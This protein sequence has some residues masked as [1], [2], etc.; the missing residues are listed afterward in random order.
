[1]GV[2]EVVSVTITIFVLLFISIVSAHV[3]ET[4]AENESLEDAMVVEEPTKSWVI[5]SELHDGQ[6]GNYYEM[7]MKEGERL[8]LSMLLPENDDFVPNMAVMGP[9]IDE[10]DTLPGFLEIPDQ[11]GVKLIEGE[12]GEREYEPF[13][14]ASYYHPAR[15]DEDINESG[16]YHVVIYTERETGGKYALAVGYQETWGPIE[17]VRLPIDVINIR[18]WEGQPLTLIF[19]PMISV[20]AMGFAWTSWK[21]REGGDVPSDVKEWSL[22][23]ASLLYIGSGAMLMVQMIIA[24]SRSDPGV[25]IMVT[26][27]FALLP[28][29]LGYKLWNK[30]SDF[31]KPT[32][33]SRVKVILYGLGGFLVWAGIIIGPSLAII[34]SFLPSKKS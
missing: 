28:L 26:I 11:T 3:P 4:G 5:Y 25:G 23:T 8:Y 19:A 17:W 13:T 30:S 22:L 15:Y 24:A 2:K 29:L 1:M 14:P 20:L 21:Y 12:L 9:G 33:W 34:S 18:I 10:N 6:V 31:E 32:R 27:L 7:D 16:T